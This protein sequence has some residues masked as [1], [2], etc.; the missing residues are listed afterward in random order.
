MHAFV[1]FYMQHKNRRE[2]QMNML[3]LLLLH[4]QTN[5]PFWLAY[6]PVPYA[7]KARTGPT[8]TPE[9]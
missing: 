5:Q 9:N 2:W 4:V 3:V 6:T 8:T 1:Y 7:G